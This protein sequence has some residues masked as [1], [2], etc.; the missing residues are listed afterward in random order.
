MRNGIHTPCSRATDHS[1]TDADADAAFKDHSA[2]YYLSAS[3]CVDAGKSD[4]TTGQQLHTGE[5]LLP[6]AD[7]ILFAHY[8]SFQ[9]YITK[10]ERV[11]PA[12]SVPASGGNVQQQQQHLHGRRLIV[13]QN[14]TTHTAHQFKL[15]PKMQREKKIAHT[16]A[17]KMADRWTKL[18]SPLFSRYN[19]CSPSTTTT[20]TINSMN[21]I[22]LHNTQ[23][24]QLK[25][26]NELLADD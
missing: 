2:N 13:S 5:M 19:K 16:M 22:E 14:D 23:R 10:H 6:I 21:S 4:R 17:E 7:T 20:T 11:C 8:K 24:A 26:E 15:A 9:L 12:I 1:D 3:D 25:R 18:I